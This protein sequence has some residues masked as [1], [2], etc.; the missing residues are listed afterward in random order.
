[1]I[2]STIYSTPLQLIGR[3][4]DIKKYEM[5]TTA[6]SKGDGGVGEKGNPYDDIGFQSEPVLP[7]MSD[8]DSKISRM[9]EETAQG[10]DVCRFYL[11]S[12]NW[13]IIEA[14]RMLKNMSE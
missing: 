13:D 2:N 5:S 1:M 6:A 14:T 3:Y 7:S 8:H 9:M 10:N 12:T 4:E 11:E